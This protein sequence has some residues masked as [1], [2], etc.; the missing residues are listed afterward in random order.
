MENHSVRF[1][2]KNINYDL[3]LTHGICNP[4]LQDYQ[5]TYEKGFDNLTK[6]ILYPTRSRF[7]YIEIKSFDYNKQNYDYI[8]NNNY[9][10]KPISSCTVIDS[11]DQTLL[12]KDILQHVMKYVDNSNNI[13]VTSF[14]RKILNMVEYCDNEI[15]EKIKSLLQPHQYDY[16]SSNNPIKVLV[17]TLFIEPNEVGNDNDDID[18]LLYQRNIFMKHTIKNGIDNHMFQI[19]PFVFYFKNDD[20]K[21]CGPVFLSKDTCE[22]FHPSCQPYTHYLYPNYDFYVSTNYEIKDNIDDQLWQN[23]YGDLWKGDFENYSKIII[24]FPFEENDN[25]SMKITYD[26]QYLNE[27]LNYQIE[28]LEY[29]LSFKLVA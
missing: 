27:K 19:L 3:V 5:F 26:F 16:D 17:D 6:T 25:I 10:Q 23:Y 11:S 9:T 15:H 28:N 18:N 29:K 4:I 20:E 8:I 24:P 13:L 1:N 14:Q 22:Q 12:K 2:N 21:Y 7:I